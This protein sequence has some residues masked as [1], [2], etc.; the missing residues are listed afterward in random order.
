MSKLRPYICLLF[1]KICYS[2]LVPLIVTPLIPFGV[3]HITKLLP[4]TLNKLS[5]VARLCHI[6]NTTFALIICTLRL[7]RSIRS[8]PFQFH[9]TVLD[10]SHCCSSVLVAD[11]NM[12]M[13]P[14]C[15]QLRKMWKEGKG[16]DTS[17]SV[18]MWRENDNRFAIRE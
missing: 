16:W 13:S 17:L 15:L 3:L 5:A 12:G 7:H 1:I 4:Q 8:L 14:R 2:S 6:R 10:T 9:T 11:G 18:W